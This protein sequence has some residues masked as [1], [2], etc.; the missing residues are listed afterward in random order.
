FYDPEMHGVNWVQMKETYQP[1]LEHV[2]DQEELHDVISMMI[3]ELNASHTG[4]GGGRGGRGGAGGGAQTRY[5]GFELEA[6]KSGYDKVTQI[7]RDGP[8]DKDYV[9]LKAGDFILA[10]DDEELKSGDNY[11]KHYTTA[12]ATKLEFTVNSKPEKE[13]AWTVKITPVSG[14]QYSSL[15]Y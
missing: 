6:R 14:G 8:A 9:K 12:P 5:P 4:I 7:Y 11:W 1:L 3:G 13:G 15:Q 10:I 2:G